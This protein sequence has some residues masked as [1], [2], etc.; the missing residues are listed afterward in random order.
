[1]SKPETECMSQQILFFELLCI[2]QSMNNLRNT[3]E[4][5]LQWMRKTS[6][7]KMTHESYSCC[8]CIIE[9]MK[10]QKAQWA[11]LQ[12][13]NHG[14]LTDQ[15]VLHIWINTIYKK[16]SPQAQKVGFNHLGQE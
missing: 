4:T 3:M 12:N 7:P 9:L 16:D 1:M 14:P 8:D 6:P 5:N 11:V 15:P 13:L 10:I 2:I